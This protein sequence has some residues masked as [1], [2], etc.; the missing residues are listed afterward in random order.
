MPN[1]LVLKDDLFQFLGRTFTNE[2]FEDLCFAFGLEIEIGNGT[3]L[4]LQRILRDGTSENLSQKTIFK[5]EVAANRY[6]LLCLEGFT[7]AIKAYLGIAPIPKLAIKNQ[8]ALHVVNVKPE[9]QGVRPYVV[10]AVLRNI[11]FT[12]QSYNSFIYL[13]D[14]LH[15]NICRRR[16]L[17]SMGTHDA[18]KVAFPVTYEARKPEDIVFRALKQTQ[19]LNGPDLMEALKKDQK[20]KK[21]LHILEGKERY[22]VFYDSEGKVLSLPPLI[23]SE[24][25]KITFDTKNVF[26]E[27]TGTDLHKLEVCLAVL[28]GQFSS[29]CKGENQFTIEQ[30]EIRHEATGKTEVFPN[31]KPNE[32]EVELAYINR[33]L[34]LQLDAEKVK[35]CAQKMGLIIKDVT[36]EGRAVKVEVPPTRTDIM[37]ACD[38]AED[39]GIAFGYNNIPRVFPPTNTVGKQIPMHKFSDLIRSELAQ[40]GYIESLTMSLLSV[41][42][43]YD[44]LRHAFKEDE[45]VVI[46]NPKTVQFEMVRSTLIPGLLKVFQSNSDESVPQRIF[47]VSDIVVLDDKKDTLAR[48]EKRV[49]VMYLN[50]S[51][52]FEVV[53]G[54][55]DL[56]MVKIGAKF[57]T[58]YYLKETADQ[59]YFPKRGADIVL[60]KK[61]IGTIGVV[62]PEV[63]EKYEIKYP[64]TCFEV[65]IDELFE[66]FKIKSD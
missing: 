9:T 57:G 48:N 16:T 22:P 6:D 32:F 11:E 66:V 45:A 14:K 13:Q 31:L 47:E 51:S 30:V 50:H 56:L 8:P 38:I 41:A 2:E 12:E 52:A 36:Q 17:G 7:Q 18:D 26:I 62:H 34:G 28:A 24:A 60:N 40:A 54:V 3:E 63:L 42:E 59:M 65:R 44:H 33:T 20:L 46:A 61:T 19:E 35:E 25:T 15:Q 49:C 55:L 4:S 1:V 27:M 39:I 10:A 5:L 58:D 21:Y 29:H 43:N 53:Q 64:V 37:H 23:N